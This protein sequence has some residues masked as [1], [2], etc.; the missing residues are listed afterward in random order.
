MAV[1]TADCD[2]LVEEIFIAAPPERVAHG[3]P[4][5]QGIP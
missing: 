1:V 4:L 5:A 3:R 2:T